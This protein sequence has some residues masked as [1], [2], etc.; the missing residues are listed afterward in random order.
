[1]A[2][3][4]AIADETKRSRVLNFRMTQAEHERLSAEATRANLSLSDYIRAKLEGESSFVEIDKEA[5]RGIH[6][7]L[8]RQGSNLNQI[9]RRLN[10]YD[11][12]E[13][14]EQRAQQVSGAITDITST[15]HK[16]NQAY[17]HLDSFIQDYLGGAI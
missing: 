11:F 5:L 2:G 9:A 3:R 12:T 15:R 6:R 10:T 8:S 4:K 14:T 16:L 17:H 1:V 13:T 7:E